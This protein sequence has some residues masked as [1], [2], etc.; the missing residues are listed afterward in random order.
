MLKNGFEQPALRKLVSQHVV[1]G[2]AASLIF[3]TQTNQVRGS[4]DYC[5]LANVT[6]FVKIAK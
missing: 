5:K 1:P 2:F 6:T 4:V 3:L